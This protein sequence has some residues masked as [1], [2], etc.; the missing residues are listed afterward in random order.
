MLYISEIVEEN[1]KEAIKLLC[2]NF[3]GNE[4]DFTNYVCDGE[5]HS[6]DNV[7]DQFPYILVNSTYYYKVE[8]HKAKYDKE[9][10]RMLFYCVYEDGNGEWINTYDCESFSENNIYESIDNICFCTQISTSN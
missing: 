4:I 2:D 10:N 8:V 9:R 6:K 1:K 5:E 3:D 7:L